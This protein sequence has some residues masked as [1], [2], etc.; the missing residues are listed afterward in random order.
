MYK[1]I[2]FLL[3]IALSFIGCTTTKYTDRIVEV[4]VEKTK[5]EYRDRLSID[6]LIMKDSILITEKGDTVYV[7]KYKYLYKIKEVR[8]TINTTDTTTITKVV[9]VNTT[10]EVNKLKTWQ[11]ILMI[12]G[13]YFV[14]FGIYK[15]YNKIKK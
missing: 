11:I 7:E 5:I 2:F 15:L 8:D 10:K 9:T 3:L 13:G 6:T 1:Y 4:P 12:L 14:I